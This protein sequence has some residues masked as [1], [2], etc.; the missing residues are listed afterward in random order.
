MKN[1]YLHSVC[2]KLLVENHGGRCCRNF[3]KYEFWKVEHVIFSKKQ[4][5]FWEW[6]ITT[7]NFFIFFKKISKEKNF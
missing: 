7:T 4:F 2:E 3:A 6:N 5:D 1:K